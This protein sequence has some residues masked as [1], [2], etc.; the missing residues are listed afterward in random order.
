VTATALTFN[1][2]LP[3]VD[4]QPALPAG[5]PAIRLDVAC[6]VG[7]AERGPLDVPVAVED[8]TQY[9][10]IFG[11]DVVLATDGGIPV[12]ANLPGAVQAFFD[13][14]GQ[15]CY[16]VRVAGP[17]ARAATWVVPGMRLY[18]PDGVAV[19]VCV[20]AAWPGSWSGGY[21]VGTQLL[22]E[23]LSIAA[24]YARARGGAPGTLRLSVASLLSVQ[25][26]DLL[27]LDVGP[28]RPGLYVR[29]GQVDAA[30]AVVA[31]DAEIPFLTS[32]GSPPEPDEP[33]E[34]LLP[35]DALAGLPAELPVSG[36]WRLQLDLIVRRVTAGNAQVAERWTALGFNQGAVPSWLD[37]IQPADGTVPD[38]TRS[39]LLRADPGTVQAA[40]RALFV[41][42]GMDQLGSAAEFT[43]LAAGPSGESPAEDGSDGLSRFDPAVMFLDQRLR[44]NETVY[45]LLTDANQLTVLAAN[46]APLQ[47]IHALIGVDDAALV[48]VPDAVHVGWSPAAPPPAPAPAPA[49]SPT[50]PDW[51]RFRDCAA[52]GACGP[53]TPAPASGAGPVAP[54][55]PRS[56]VPVPPVLDDPAGYE[57][58]GLLEVH[59][60]LVQLC[61]ARSDL[62]AVL[63]V[64]RHYDTTAA[65]GWLRQLGASAQPTV[66]GRILLSPLSFAGF[67]HPWVRVVER[68]SPALA[69]LRDQPADGAACGMIAARELARGVWVAPADV[70]LRGPVGLA[71][72]LSGDD[73]VRLFDAHANLLRSQP[74]SISALSAHTLATEPNLLQV[75][76]RRLIILLRKIALQEGSRYVFDTN[77]DRFRQLVRARFER[78]L[79]ALAG[80]GAL[81]AYQVVTG[82]GT[83]TADGELIVALQVAP[84]SPIE[85]ITVSLVRAGENLLDVV[86]G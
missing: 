62:F 15:R 6:F 5:P 67:W 39:L 64:P 57:P 69:P 80:L 46:P 38:Q 43:D 55:A 74:G 1:G 42:A 37:V 17:D 44:W 81:A 53:A 50:P 16:V 26:G 35:P 31:A 71:T 83:G 76:V 41:P 73:T 20:Q 12:Y 30:N 56:P 58:A 78:I 52:P 7:F 63:G 84:T 18:Y 86:A 13:N 48:S 32:A 77:T 65:L 34:Q 27:R 8:P 36:A 79:A 51:S 45:S 33:D 61:A 10:T 14:G 66:S 82:G 72:A 40:G 25:P 28:G 85:F 75:S 19:D 54:A 9:A 4:C 59:A 23:P 11:G 21:Q 2:R 29:V 68:T 47:G 49:A 22:T 70:P 3:G 24:P 60:A